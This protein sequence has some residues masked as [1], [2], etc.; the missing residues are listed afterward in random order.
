MMLRIQVLG[1]FRVEVNGVLLPADRWSRRDVTRLLQLLALHAQHRLRRDQIAES[2]WPGADAE[3]TRRRLYNTLYLLRNALE[4]GRGARA[5]SR[6]VTSKADTVGLG[7]P[8]ELWVDADE[9][10]RCLDQAAVSEANNEAAAR[11]LDDA[12]ALYQGPLLHQAGDEPW[13]GTDGAH[14]EQRFRGALRSLA[15][16][17]QALGHDDAAIAAWQRL[18]RAEPSDEAAQC[19]LMEALER[20]GRRA[21]ALAQ[22]RRAKEV[23]A[24]ELGVAPGVAA[25]ALYRRL[26][27]PAECEPIEETTT[28]IGVR[29]HRAPQ[30]LCT[31]IGR[32]A[33]LA[34]LRTLVEQPDARL[35]TLAGMGGV[36]KTRLAL[37]LAAELQSRFTHGAAFVDLSAVDDTDRV[38]GSMAAALGLPTA[39]GASAQ[40]IVLTYLANKQLLLVVDNFEQVLGAARCLRELLEQA[41]QVVVLV[42]SRTPLHLRGERLFEVPPLALPAP[43]D[44]GSTERLARVASVA[45]F[46]AGA[47]AVDPGFHLNAE[48]A[49]DVAALCAQLDG[50][51]LAIELAAARCRL[52]APHEL[53][54]RL[55]HADGRFAL[56]CHVG[57]N[58]LPRH[59]S[60][61]AVLA[62]SY[63]LLPP[64][65]QRLLT[66]ISVFR[67]GATLVSIE[68]LCGGSAADI[69]TQ[70]DTLLDHHLLHVVSGRLPKRRFSAPDSVLA[71]AQELATASAVR[72]TLARR[73]AEHFT[74]LAEALAPLLRGPEQQLG[75]DRIGDEMGNLRAALAWATEHDTNLAYR[76]AAAMAGYWNYRGELAEGLSSY[77]KLLAQPAQVTPTVQ[78]RAAYGAATL[79]YR[80]GEL[81][82]ASALIERSVGLRGDVD[83][84]DVV[85]NALTMQAAVACARDEHRRA[86]SVMHEALALGRQAGAERI[87]GISL[88]NIGAFYTD[89][90]LFDAAHA[91]LVEGLAVVRKIDHANA[92]AMGLRNLGVLAN[93]RGQTQEAEALIAEALTVARRVD[94][95]SQVAVLQMILAEMRAEG[96]DQD[97]AERHGGQGLAL[98][99]ETGEKWP[100]AFGLAVLGKSAY[101]RGTPARGLAL[102]EECRACHAACGNW[103]N[104]GECLRFMVRCEL[105]LGRLPQARSYLE[106]LV[107]HWQRTPS[108]ATAD[109]LTVAAALALADHGR[110]ALAAKALGCAAAERDRSG[111]QLAVSEQRGLQQDIDRARQL[112]GERRFESLFAL[113]SGMSASVV[114]AGARHEPKVEPSGPIEDA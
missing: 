46:V 101:Y 26:A 54:A 91:A 96:G 100:I 76:L 63:E 74:A 73:H 16:A 109:M 12:V 18:V 41:A 113:G 28:T 88:I 10:E 70:V 37:R 77:R 43:G 108:R 72:A 44:T 38:A 7:P 31:L 56:L 94:S 98:A 42:T 80:L 103:K 55:E 112:L 25:Q 71:Y 84:V 111:L 53:R 106:E 48:N 90:G 1:E 5:P 93:G 110:A 30:A 17:R 69:E 102:L 29:I 89:V 60:L 49:G 79:A 114:L 19:S 62:W 22:Y 39:G 6:H 92:I 27:A 65:A 35:V 15:R 3:V 66:E 59:R 50:L 34:A 105:A 87:V 23:L 52:F 20:T 82:E 86:L 97:G 78:A 58:D 57:S 36:G 24:T 81:D 64:A 99:R 67:G 83:D 68:A 95:R 40:E 2:L 75:L 13:I 32:D 104:Y 4:P 8:G 11:Q 85:V 14:L 45:L 9:F 33:D 47:Q 107:R 51:P 21:E 61:R